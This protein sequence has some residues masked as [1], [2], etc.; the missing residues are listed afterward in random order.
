MSEAPQGAN[1]KLLLAYAE[2]SRDLAAPLQKAFEAAGFDVASCTDA[3][4]TGP[5]ATDGAVAVVVCW[6]P[7]AVA[8]DVV[9]LQA[10]RI[11]TLG[12]R[13]EDVFLIEGPALANARQ[14]IQLE[15]DL[16]AA[17]QD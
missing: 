13:V 5:E 9:N 16:L 6:T 2:S 1:R 15:N 10:A 4:P 14:Q 8:S 12:E 7:A 17:M 3:R 11:M